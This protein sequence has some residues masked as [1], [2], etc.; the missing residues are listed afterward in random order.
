VEKLTASL[1]ADVLS[2]KTPVSKTLLQQL[3]KSDVVDGS[4]TSLDALT[5]TSSP[6]PMSAK[7][8]TIASP[9]R[10]P[11]QAGTSQVGNL[12]E[13]LVQLMEQVS[14]ATAVSASLC[15]EIIACAARLRA[16]LSENR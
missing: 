14:S 13:K 6:A 7:S 16:A 8:E 4:V 15:D 2:G 3:G 9:T 5:D 10:R 11:R 12:R 1:K